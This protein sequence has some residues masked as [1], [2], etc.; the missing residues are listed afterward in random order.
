MHEKMK[1]VFCYQI[2]VKSEEKKHHMLQFAMH[3]IS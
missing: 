1:G 3:F 2:I